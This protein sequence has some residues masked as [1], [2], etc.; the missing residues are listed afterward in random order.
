MRRYFEVWLQE[1]AQGRKGNKLLALPSVFFKAAVQ[2]RHALYDKGFFKQKQAPL[3]VVSIGNLV[4]GG[5]GKTQIAL[6]LAKELQASMRVALLCR[7][8]RAKAENRSSP[9]CVDI[10]MHPPEECGDEPWLLASRLPEALV[11]S[12]KNRTA[13]S[14]EA[15]KKGA[16]VAILDDGMQHRR[17]KRDIEIVVVDGSNPFGG[18]FFLPRGML[19]DDPKRLQRAD[20]VV[21]VGKVAE[22]DKKKIAEL[23]SA[24]CVQ[25]VIV[26]GQIKTLKGKEIVLSKGCRVGV[27]CGIG[28]PERF[29]KQVEAMGFHAVATHALPDH[30]KIGRKELEAFAILSKKKGAGWLLCTE[31]DKVKLLEREAPQTLPIGWIQADLEIVDNREAWEK[32]LN[33]IKQLAGISL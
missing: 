12:G 31:K 5:T 16:Q 15:A 21:I 8:F 23:T 18:G 19:R 10:A 24:C 11:L 9:L 2:A 6:L 7:G 28:L 17:L 27:F 14:I 13:S 25:A 32:M 20:L 26:P 22:S 29:F 3:P 4:A 1:Q 30:K 33:R